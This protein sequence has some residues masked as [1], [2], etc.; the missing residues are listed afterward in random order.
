MMKTR[1]LYYED[2]HLRTFTA[3]VHSCEKTEKGWE[4]V[5]DATAFYPEGGGQAG[6]LHRLPRF[7][8]P[9]HALVGRFFTTQ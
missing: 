9:S 5:L 4:V 1:K 6:V 7:E 8:P 3:K 2:S